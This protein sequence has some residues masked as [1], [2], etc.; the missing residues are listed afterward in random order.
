[1]LRYRTIVIRTLLHDFEGVKTYFLQRRSEW[2]L[3]L[4]FEKGCVYT[5]IIFRGLFKFISTMTYFHVSYLQIGTLYHK[6]I[7]S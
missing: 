5:S 7:D 3:L 4:E 6:F 1:M 2:S